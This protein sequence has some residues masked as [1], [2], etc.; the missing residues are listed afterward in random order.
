MRTLPAL[1]LLLSAVAQGDEV[2]IAEKDV[3]DQVLAG[4]RHAHPGA[5]IVKCERE[6]TK[7]LTTYEVRV[8]FAEGNT[9]RT[10]DVDLDASGRVLSEE[11]PLPLDALPTAVR[12]AATAGATVKLLRAERIMR[13]GAKPSYEV[14]VSD[15]H[16][17]RELTF[18]EQGHLQQP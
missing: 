7:D 2:M 10:V 17:T 8:T 5:V 16:G 6:R 15:S 4:V 3:P 14:V 9:K 13:Q 1:L 18:D 11:E 12:N